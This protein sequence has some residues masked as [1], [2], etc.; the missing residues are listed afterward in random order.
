MLVMQNN[1][2]RYVFILPRPMHKY[3]DEFRYS[4]GARPI[5]GSSSSGINTRQDLALSSSSTATQTSAEKSKLSTTMIFK[6]SIVSF[7]ALFA[8]FALAAATP[9]PVEKRWGT[10]TTTTTHPVTTTITV[11]APGATGTVAAGNCNTGPI[12]CC[13]S[14]T[15]VSRS[16]AHI[17]HSF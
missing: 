5:T 17:L 9:A 12:Q 3:I 6:F 1:S 7:Y 16:S 15:T 4:F 10:P 14:T 13:Q 11:T 8:L 2:N